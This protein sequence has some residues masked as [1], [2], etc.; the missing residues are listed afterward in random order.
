MQ[1]DEKSVELLDELFKEDYR[2]DEPG[3]A[4]LISINE[5]IVYQRCFGL[6]NVDKNEMITANSNFRLASLTKQFTAYGI[7]LLEKENR[8][9]KNDF[10]DKYLPNGFKDKCPLISQKITIQHLLEHTS[11]L[12]DY[13][14][15]DLSIHDQWLDNDVLNIIEDRTLFEPGSEYRYS[16]TGYIILGLIIEQVS[17]KTLG[18]FFHN[19]IFQ[20]F[21]MQTSVLYD[22]KHALITHR[23]LGYK[24]QMDEYRLCDQSVTSATGGD[25]GIYTSLNDYFQWYRCC[26]FNESTSP[27]PIESTPLF[28]TNGWFLSDSTGQIRSHTGFSCGFTHQ[29]YRIDENNRKILVLYLTNIGECGDR[30][31]KFN[32]FLIEH[33]PQLIPNNIQLLWEI[34][35]ITR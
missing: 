31:Q 34:K 12:I 18:E 33:F 15:Y 10:I 32:R 3:A 1:F 22:P 17:T 2:A 30:I 8:L 13:E 16:N 21:H 28:Y 11:G 5:E 24:K 14:D 26:Q 9:S 20:P 19:S 29:V 35:D 25:G 27:F 4:I 7:H 23:V 6:G